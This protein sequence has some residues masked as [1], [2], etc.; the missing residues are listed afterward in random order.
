[1]IMSAGVGSF[2]KCRCGVRRKTLEAMP[3]NYDARSMAVYTNMMNDMSEYEF[4]L[5]FLLPEQDGAASKYLDRLFEA[6]C[7]DAVVGTGM[8]GMIS[9][10]FNRYAES[11][12]KAITSAIDAVMEAIPN[13]RL[14][15]AK[16]DMVG[17]S[18]VATIVGCSRQNIRKYAVGHPGFPLPTVTGR[19]QLWHLWEI[20]RFDKFSVPDTMVDVA[21]VTCKV[22][23]DLQSQR[24]AGRQ[25]STF[26]QLPP[27]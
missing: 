16:P 17:L 23:L 4:T 3:G 2:A 22:N 10:T 11:A 13:A 15:E 20:A 26:G 1:M 5:T 21:Q 24:L 27:T 7:D 25:S 8:A 14:V 19:V 18:D 6:G 9:L 12:G